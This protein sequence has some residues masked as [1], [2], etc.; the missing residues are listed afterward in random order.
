M[1]GPNAIHSVN[2][3]ITSD[4]FL[5]I[6]ESRIL[7]ETQERELTSWGLYFPKRFMSPSWD[8]SLLIRRSTWRMLGRNYDDTQPLELPA[9]DTSIKIVS[10][11]LN[12]VINEKIKKLDRAIREFPFEI[13]GLPVVEDPVVPQE[14]IGPEFYRSKDNF[15]R[16]EN[17]SFY[18]V[19]YSSNVSVA[20]SI[21]P[22]KLSDE[23]YDFCDYI[24][25]QLAKI[26]DCKSDEVTELFEIMPKEFLENSIKPRIQ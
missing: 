23:I 18:R 7:K 20:W 1:E 13:D 5:R 26:A 12:R 24:D 14:S 8:T 6:Q 16:S 21:F 25:E 17:M 3:N 11:D 4:L 22:A 9:V 19:G 15:L 10:R 2:L